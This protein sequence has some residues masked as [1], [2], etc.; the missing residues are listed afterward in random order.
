MTEAQNQKPK[1][2]VWLDLETTGLDPIYDQII[3]IGV[4]VT[5]EKLVEI[6]RFHRVLPL[7]VCC[8]WSDLNMPQVVRDM[9]KASGLEAEVRA[10]AEM[11]WIDGEDEAHEAACRDLSAFLRAHG[12]EKAPLAGNSVGDFDR[13]FLRAWESMLSVEDGPLSILSHRSLNVSTFFVLAELWGAPV[14]PKGD[15]HRS[16]ADIESSIRQFRFYTTNFYNL[17]AAACVMLDEG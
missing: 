16:I 10:L 11:T 15:A 1:R 6:A 3:E 2:I 14:A 17:A 13:H 5:D 4:I 7:V 9:H 12:C 8:Y